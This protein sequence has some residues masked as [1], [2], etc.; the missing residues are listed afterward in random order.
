MAINVIYNQSNYELSQ[1]RKEIWDK[2]NKIILWG[3]KHPLRFAE[4]FLGLQFTDHQKYIFMNSWVSKFIT[5]VMSRSSGKSYLSAPYVM[6]RSLLIPNHQTYIMSVTGAQSKETFKK[7]ENLA[8]GQIASVTGSTSVFLNEL[9]KP[10]SNSQ[11]FTHDKNSYHCHLYNGSS[12]YTLNSIINNTVGIRSNLNL[13]DEAGKIEK[14]F[15]ALSKPFTVQNTDFITGKGINFDCYPKQFPNQIILA[16][17]AEDIFTELW[18]SYKQGAMEMMMGNPEYFVCD[19]DC[20][21]SLYPKMDGKPCTPLLTQS[22]IDEAIAQNEFRA[23]REYYNKFDTTGGED[24]LV[25]KT[26]LDKCSQSY[27][28]VFEYEDGKK[29]VLI[30]DPSSKLDNSV[31]MVFEIF[32]DNEKGWMG[33]VVNCKNLIETKNNGEKKVIQK[34]DQL[35]IIKEMMLA[36]NGPGLEYKNIQKIVFDAGAGGGGFDMAQFIMPEWK[37]RDGKLHL[38]II[39]KEDKYSK[40][41][42]SRFP[43][44]VPILTLANFTKD[45]VDMYEKASDALNQG[46]IIFP[47]EMTARGEM[48]FERENADGDIELIYEKLSKEEIRACVEIDML[49]YELMAMQKNKNSTSLKISYDTI[50]S[51]KNEGVK[52]DRADCMAMFCHYLMNLRATEKLNNYKK[53]TNNYAVLSNKRKIA[54]NNMFDRRPNPFSGRGDNPFKR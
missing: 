34:P 47:K 40:E 23:N 37:G 35:N 53:N 13:Y 39:D 42:I 48:E 41:L 6:T 19:I 52:D 32:Q 31:I 20:N 7:M 3:R 30:W 27:F 50:P 38:G 17:S 51:K 9:E 25:R 45:K 24:C 36:Y 15:F 11:G 54:Q 46:L 49:K 18:E 28:P 5:W 4:H 26:T 44:A 8:L 12:I 21:F 29:Y 43:S 10:N 33:K 1:R 16:S 14:E 2:Y 22:T